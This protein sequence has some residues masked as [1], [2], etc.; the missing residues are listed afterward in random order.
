MKKARR[1]IGLAEK[2]LKVAPAIIASRQNLDKRRVENAMA[3][4]QVGVDDNNIFQRFTAAP[5]LGVND[6][7]TVTNLRYAPKTRLIR[8]C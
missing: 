1:F 4:L 6:K 7:L 2:V 3:A 5:P 8:M